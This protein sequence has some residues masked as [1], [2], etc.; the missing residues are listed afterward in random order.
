MEE[1][2]HS[3]P[4]EWFIKHLGHDKYHSL[5]PVMDEGSK[6][7]VLLVLWVCMD[8]GQIF[9]SDKIRVER[10]ITEDMK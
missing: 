5:E 10:D 4:K 6:E 8:C 2:L 1:N 3:T 9:Y 7:T